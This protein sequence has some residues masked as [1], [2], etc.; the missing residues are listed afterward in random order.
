MGATLTVSGLRHLRGGREVLRI[1]ELSIAAGQRLAVLGPNGS[2]KTTLLRLLAGLEPPTGGTVALDGDPTST[3]PMAARRSIGYVTQQ[4][5]LLNVSVRRNVEL[6]LAWRGLSRAARRPRAAAALERL[7]VAHLADRPA[8]QLSGGE[9]QRVNL[10]RSLVLDPAVLLLDEPAAALDPD[11]R[12]SFLDDLDHVLSGES[13]TVVHVSHHPEE[14]IRGAHRVVVLDAGTIRQLGTPTHVFQAPADLRV[15]RI[16]GYQNLLPVEIDPDGV[17]RLHG[18]PLATVSSRAG[19]PATLAVWASGV[20]VGPPGPDA[21]VATVDA[22]TP[23]PGRW[24]VALDC[25]PR[26]VAYV[27]SDQPPPRRGEQLSLW[28]LPELIAVVPPS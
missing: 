21:V 4:P 12:A 6:P 19:G 17:V 28:L 16:V 18:Q 8:H 9:R 2:G 14:A 15:A 25:G 10:A 1:D 11:G 3:L 27:R 24:E 23:G 26:I 7:G 20:E 5:G 22:V 13:T